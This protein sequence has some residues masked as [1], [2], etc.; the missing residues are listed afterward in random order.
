MTLKPKVDSNIALILCMFY[1]DFSLP[2]DDKC[3]SFF[4]IAPGY[5]I[6]AVFVIGVALLG[7]TSFEIDTVPMNG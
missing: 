3:K 5:V 6:T 4:A 1:F 2:A 7:Q